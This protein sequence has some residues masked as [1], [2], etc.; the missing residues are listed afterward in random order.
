MTTSIELPTGK[1]LNIARFIALI[2]VTNSADSSYHL[3]LEGYPHHINLE[4]SDAQALK[5]F[6]ELD[7]DNTASTNQTVWDK[8]KQILKNQRAMELLAKRMEH[9]DNIS[10]SEAMERQEFFERFKQIMDA[11]RP[12]GQKL[13]SES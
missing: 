4:S 13:Y 2:P 8:D 11:E 10:D 9:D 5:K 3:I 12:E 6:L 1:I 7:K